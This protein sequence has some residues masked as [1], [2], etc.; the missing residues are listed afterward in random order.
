MAYLDIPE[1]TVAQKQQIRTLMDEYVANKSIFEYHSTNRRESYAYT[2]ILSDTSTSVKGC[3]NTSGKYLL[4]CG[5]FAQM[6]WLGR[7]IEDFTGHISKPSTAITKAF[8]WGYYFDF[9]GAK[10]AYK[11]TKADGSY[12]SSNTYTSASGSTIFITF[13]NASAMADELHRKGY[14]IPYGQADIGDLVF[15]RSNS[16]ADGDNDNLEATNFRS[17]NHVGIVYEVN[18]D[19]TLTILECT[20]AYSGTAIGKCWLTP[21]SGT[22]TFNLMRG[23]HVNYRVVMCARHPA[24]YGDGGNVPTKF[25]SY[26]RA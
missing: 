14:E 26:R 7:K 9:L 21:A 19:G 23:S 8:D 4:N 12:Y 16:D 13:D 18:P 25:T 15:Y 20:T 24:A 22:G 5:V 3:M 11:V 17:I 1:L 6:I 2:T 10:H